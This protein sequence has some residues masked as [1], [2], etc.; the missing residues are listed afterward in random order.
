MG[1]NPTVYVVEDDPSVL[2]AVGRILALEGF[3]ARLFSSPLSFLAQHDPAKL[4]CIVI[5]VALPQLSGLELQSKLRQASSAQPVVFIS[6]SSDVPTSVMAMKGGAVDFLTK[7]FA[8]DAFLES[9]RQAVKRDQE[10]RCRAAE[11][12][13]VKCRLAKLTPREWAVLRQVVDGRLNKQIAGDLGI[14]EKTVKVHRGR[15]MRKMGVRTVAEL[16]KLVHSSLAFA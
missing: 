1:L 15:G 11:R 2:K 12:D 6:G 10:T 13:S 9:V 8:R 16:V 5:D 7:P 3:D 4:G 14:V